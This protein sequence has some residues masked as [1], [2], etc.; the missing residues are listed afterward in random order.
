MNNTHAKNKNKSKYNKFLFNK[1][2]NEKT[3]INAHL[4]VTNIFKCHCLHHL[5]FDLGVGL[6]LLCHHTVGLD[7][8]LGVGYE[9]GLNVGGAVNTAGNADVKLKGV[10]RDVG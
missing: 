10:G 1:H 7:V 5:W 2:S 3:Q 4:Q 9:V 8:G 6:G